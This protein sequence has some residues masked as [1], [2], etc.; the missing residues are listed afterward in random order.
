MQ[1]IINTETALSTSFEQDERLTLNLRDSMSRLREVED[2]RD[3]L[4]FEL[5]QAREAHVAMSQKSTAQR[6]RLEAQLREIKRAADDILGPTARDR[7][8]YLQ[9]AQ[10]GFETQKTNTQEQLDSIQR[11]ILR[12]TQAS[13]LAE[14]D[15]RNHGQHDATELRELVERYDDD[16][17]K[18]DA[19]IEEEKA[20]LDRL[21]TA[22]TKFAT[23][24]VRID[25]DRR[26]MIEEQR[27]IDTT[28]RLRR[29]REANL[30]GFILRIQAVVRGFLA[31][32]RMR[33][34]AQK[35]RRR[36]RKKGKKGKK[37][38]STSPGRKKVVKKTGTKVRAKKA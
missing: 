31:R 24:F 13:Q 25:R 36:Y 9:A 28:E 1:L 17:L 29:L 2:D 15:E 19:A 33:L 20:E 11:T 23:Y 14:A 38:T 7:E 32:R 8:E 34:E 27:A 6:S 10:S 26:N 35:K 3:Q 5:A 12:I 22:N 37:K 4:A 18:L 30:F 16:M 21:D